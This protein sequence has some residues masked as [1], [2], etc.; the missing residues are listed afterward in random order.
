MRSDAVP[1]CL[2]WSYE[3]LAVSEKRVTFGVVHEDGR[4]ITGLRASA[5]RTTREARAA[6]QRET[7]GYETAARRAIRELEGRRA[8]EDRTVRYDC[9]VKIDRAP[10]LTRARLKDAVAG[11]NGVAAFD[12]QVVGESMI[13]TFEYEDETGVDIVQAAASAALDLVDDA[14]REALGDGTRADVQRVVV[15]RVP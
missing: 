10:G 15:E 3:W 5:Y 2:D 12:A 11:L 4:S 7:V 6:G 14:V 1:G 8:M 13:V 9:E